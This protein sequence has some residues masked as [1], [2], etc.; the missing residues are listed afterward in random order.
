MTYRFASQMAYIGAHS[1]SERLLL[2]RRLPTRPFAIKETCSTILMHTKKIYQEV[3]N[4][5]GAITKS[6]TG[7]YEQNVAKAFG[8]TEEELALVPEGANLGL[9]CGNPLALARLRRVC[10]SIP[11]V[12]LLILLTAERAKLSL[13]SDLALAL[14]YSQLRRELALKEGLLEL[15]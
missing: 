10:L 15:I 1:P 9:S 12:V 6:D 11:S 4:R 3:N 7:R 14:M 2:S 13:T 5:Y 8:Y